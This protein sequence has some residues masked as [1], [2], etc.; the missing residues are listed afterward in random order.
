[1]KRNVYI[2]N[3][4]LKQTQ[5][6]FFG[7]IQ[8]NPKVERIPV[9]NALSRMT[10]DGVFAK[11]SSPGY[12]AAAM[13]GIAVFS[14]TTESAR[15]TAP[16]ILEEDEYSYINTGNPLPK[17]ADAVIMIE[18]VVDLHDGTV[19]I[20]QA[21]HSWQHVRPIG[22]DIV[23]TELIV[24]KNHR[25]RPVDLAALLAGGITEVSVYQKPVVGI[26]PTGS[27]IVETTDEVTHGKI[28]DSNSWMVAGLI[29]EAGG[30]EKRY[31]P[32][33]DDPEKLR[34]AILKATEEVDILLIGAGSSAGNK[35]FTRVLIEELGEVYYHGI[36]IKPGKP[37]VL[38]MIGQVPV[39]GMPGYPVSAYVSYREF[40][41]PIIHR[42]TGQEK[43]QP[44]VMA[45]LTSD[46]Y[47]SVK[48]KEYIR[49]TLGKIDGQWMATP[50]KTGAGVSMSLVRADGIG[51]IPQDVEGMAQGEEIRVTLLK[52]LQELE[53]N[54]VITGSHD[55]VIDVLRDFIPV[56]STHVGS[57]GGIFA[58]LQGQ[59]TLAPI[60]L[61]NPETG[62][63]NISYVREFFQDMA[64]IKGVERI[65]GLMVQPGNPKNIHGYE[66]LGLENLVFI[67]R[68]SGAG[69]RILLDYRLDERNIHKE[70]ILGYDNAVT[71]HMQ[72]AQAVKAGDADVGLGA[73]SAAHALGL[74]FIETDVEEYDFLVRVKD[75][76]DPR[77][78]RFIE[79]L[80]S[81]A[82][83]EKVMAMG[84]YVLSHVG[85]VV[86]I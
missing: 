36:A 76:E 43:L 62:E 25:I 51:T 15:P 20:H 37:T 26:L 42:L 81:D 10:S 40:V 29:E 83:K 67:N 47:S 61:L 70:S 58:L 64:L 17:G 14:M 44:T 45:K 31:A 65:Q 8:L 4:P 34:A 23:E 5:E 19:R 28:I 56:T 2:H 73:Y 57:M 7:A 66:D 86:Y 24:P 11:K 30:L 1:M 71:T 53:E 52:P 85:E 63:Y 21:A 55:V 50:M 79:T 18:D 84:G 49:V 46:V 27:E 59:A 78:L 72:V 12:N 39:I 16:L 77:V 3:H 32:V 38:G 33:E 22:E 54:L 48:H 13:D 60:H 74:D 68:Q 69:T 41:E 75:L 9:T 82:F 80:Q 6:G 35:D